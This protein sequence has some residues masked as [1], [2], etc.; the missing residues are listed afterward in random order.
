[1]RRRRENAPRKSRPEPRPSRMRR[2]ESR[3]AGSLRTTQ[4]WRGGLNKWQPPGV[5]HFVVAKRPTNAHIARRQARRA[6]QEG[7]PDARGSW[8]GGWACVRAEKNRCLHTGANRLHCAAVRSKPP[9]LAPSPKGMPASEAAGAC[10]APR[11]HQSSA[12]SGNIM[13]GHG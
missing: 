11:H 7:G 12:R 3:C 8:A 9:C 10:A 5:R 4:N 1:L 6:T 2:P 13:G